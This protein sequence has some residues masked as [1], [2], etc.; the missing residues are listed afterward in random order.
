MTRARK[1]PSS[2]RDE[3]SLAGVLKEIG[4]LDLPAVLH[5]GGALLRVLRGEHPDDVRL[6]Q[7]REIN[8]A[9]SLQQLSFDVMR[10]AA[11]CTRCVG[12]PCPVCAFAPVQPNTY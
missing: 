12:C 3:F 2:K 5:R 8:R 1:T 9:E 6:D 4:H 11:C 7:E 10:Q